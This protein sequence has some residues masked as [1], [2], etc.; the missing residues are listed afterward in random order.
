LLQRRDGSDRAD[1][2]ERVAW[3]FLKHS[4]GR[5]LKRPVEPGSLTAEVFLTAEE[6]RTGGTVTVEIPLPSSCTECDGTGGAALNCPRCD[7]DGVT[8]SRL[9]VPL[10]VPPHTREG[11]V[12][13]VHLDEPLVSRLLVVVHTRL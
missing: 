8:T 12:F 2:A 13:Q 10:R 5:E 9:P 3:S 7:G 1:R 4:D 11:T 6:A